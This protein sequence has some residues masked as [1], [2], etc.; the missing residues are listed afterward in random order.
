[1]KR[2][3]TLHTNKKMAQNTSFYIIALLHLN[4][5]LITKPAERY[6]RRDGITT[7][8]FLTQKISKIPCVYCNLVHV[9]RTVAFLTVRS[10][11]PDLEDGI[12]GLPHTLTA[13]ITSTSYWGTWVLECRRTDTMY[14][15]CMCSPNN[16]KTE[17]LNLH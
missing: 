5:L 13:M 15:I 14:V 17:G 7:K 4:V 16:A 9:F 10:L 1:M 11:R 8:R 6:R 12:K 3:R 2:F